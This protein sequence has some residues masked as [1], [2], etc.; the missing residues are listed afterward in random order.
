MKRVLKGW[1]TDNPVA[2]GNKKEKILQPHLAGSLTLD[3]IINRMDM[4]NTGL[5]RETLEHVVD[6]FQRK[7][8]ETVSEGYSVSTGL[9]RAA[10][11]FRGVIRDGKWDPKT[12]TVYASFMQEKYMR[13]AFS[14]ASVNI[15]GEKGDASFVLSSED[16]STH[17]T[18]GTAT[19]GRNYILRGR[20]LKVAGEDPANGITL[21]DS[22]GTE[23]RFPEDMIVEN[24]PSEILL[25]LPKELSDDTYTITITT[26]YAGSGRLLK[27]PRRIYWQII[28]GT[29]DVGKGEGVSV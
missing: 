26:Q 15:L 25:L 11:Q 13:Q 14:A 16:T 8:A 2:T 12:N 17:A 21:T 19:P 4:E 6:L 9:F 18:N 5:R 10:P 23:W 22:Q 28:V 24:M 29:T 20:Y 3:D 7:V 1:L 27:V